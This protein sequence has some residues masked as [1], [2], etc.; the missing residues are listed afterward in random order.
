MAYASPAC[1]GVELSTAPADLAPRPDGTHHPGA[2]L[3]HPARANRR[4]RYRR[5]P[6]VT[7]GHPAR[8]I[9]ELPPLHSSVASPAAKELWLPGHI[10]Y[11]AETSASGRDGFIR[12]RPARPG[13]QDCGYQVPPPSHRGLYPGVDR[14]LAQHFDRLI[15]WL[16]PDIQRPSGVFLSSA[17]PS[18]PSQHTD[19]N[20]AHTFALAHPW[21]LQNECPSKYAIR[22]AS[23][24]GLS[25]SEQLLSE[26]SR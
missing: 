8:Q 20:Q 14:Q 16:R 21:P 7:I 2:A 6:P 26:Q 9:K 15:L 4:A 22:I 5:L 17:L 3:H 23:R 24:S 13:P 11:R 10:A 25:R 19:R 12:Q 18:H 1:M